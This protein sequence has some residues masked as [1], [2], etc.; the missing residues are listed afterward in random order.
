MQ[1]TGRLDRLRDL[2]EMWTRV[3]EMLFKI[4]FKILFK[5]WLCTILALILLEL[6]TMATGHFHEMVSNGQTNRA[7]VCRLTYHH[8]P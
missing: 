7:V 6:T 1:S 8:R 5:S 3:V 4:L 2:S